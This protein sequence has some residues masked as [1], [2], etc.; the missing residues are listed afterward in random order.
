[1]KIYDAK[2]LEQKIK[3]ENHGKSV[4]CLKYTSDS[5]NLISSGEDLHINIS[6]VNAMQRK[7]T[8]I[9]HG[10]TVTSISCH[11][12]NPNIFLTSSLDKSIKIWD[13]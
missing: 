6:D 2:N 13:S 12:T 7:Q 4:V 5:K 8:L 11:P 1:M 9:G 3:F 10:D